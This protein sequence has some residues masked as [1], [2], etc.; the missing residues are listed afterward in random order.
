MITLTA[1]RAFRA[2]ANRFPSTIETLFSRTLACDTTV[3]IA[4]LHSVTVARTV[5]LASSSR[6]LK[7]QGFWCICRAVWPILC[8]RKRWG[9]DDRRILDTPLRAKFDGGFATRPPKADA[10]CQGG[11]AE[12]RPPCSSRRPG[13]GIIAPHPTSSCSRPLTPALPSPLKGE[14]P[15]LLKR[16]RILHPGGRDTSGGVPARECPNPK[17]QRGAS[18][19]PRRLHGARRLRSGFG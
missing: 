15:P 11:T 8:E 1:H 10:A 13:Y 12:P 19:L 4:L 18:P 9:H 7:D 3:F 16:S 17:R 5:S 6:R 2:D 14:G